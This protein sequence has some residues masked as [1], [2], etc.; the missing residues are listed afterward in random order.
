MVLQVEGIAD[1]SV[2]AE[3]SLCGSGRL[4]PLHFLLSS[5]HDL[6]R[7][8]GPVINAPSLL[9]PAGQAHGL[10]CGA[11]GAQRHCQLERP[12]YACFVGGAAAR[13]GGL[14]CPPIGLPRSSGAGPEEGALVR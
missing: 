8:F 4:E 9:M 6:V 10:E 3:K 13:G 2:G 7:I 14:L 5:S 12:W 11:V 1:G